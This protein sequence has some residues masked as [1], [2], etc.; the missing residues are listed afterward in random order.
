[1]GI[2]SKINLFSV[3]TRVITNIRARERSSGC[4]PSYGPSGIDRPFDIIDCRGSRRDDL[5]IAKLIV[6]FAMDSHVDGRPQAQ[7]SS[8]ATRDLW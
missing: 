8:V 2:S 6:S 1:M 7:A 3:N 5:R 4:D